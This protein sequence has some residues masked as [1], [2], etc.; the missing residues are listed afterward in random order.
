MI[1]LERIWCTKNFPQTIFSHFLNPDT[2]IK[3]FISFPMIKSVMKRSW[4]QLQNMVKGRW[5]ETPTSVEMIHFVYIYCNSPWHRLDRE[6]LNEFICRTNAV[7][8]FCLLITYWINNIR[9][10]IKWAS[11]HLPTY[12]RSISSEEASPKSKLLRF[13]L[14]YFISSFLMWISPK[15][16]KHF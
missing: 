4:K 2:I 14:L 3:V 6:A 5:P 11:A 12:C 10:S 1:Q 13:N 15:S 7:I 16:M 9:S 8:Y